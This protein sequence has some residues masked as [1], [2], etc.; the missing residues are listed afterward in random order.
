M[1]NYLVINAL[2]NLLFCVPKAAVLHGKSVGFAA[3]KSRFRNAKSKLAFFKEII[4]T[5]LRLFLFVGLK[6]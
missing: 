5:K 1:C 6:F 2:Q 4:F 3:Q